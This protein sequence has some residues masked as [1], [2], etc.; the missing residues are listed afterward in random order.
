MRERS[1]QAG[2]RS[3]RSAET[4]PRRRP[5]RRPPC[6]PT[7]QRSPALPPPRAPAQ[8]AHRP[9]LRQPRR[10]WEPATKQ[11]GGD[12]AEATV[13]AHGTPH[14]QPGS[15]GSGAPLPSI[16][17]PRATL[18]GG[19]C[20]SGVPRAPVNRRPAA[21]AAA[22][23]WGRG[24]EEHG[25]GG[26]SPRENAK[27]TLHSP[28]F[29][30]PPFSCHPKPPTATTTALASPPGA[31]S[32]GRRGL[33]EEETLTSQPFPGLGWRRRRKPGLRRQR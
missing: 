7:A 11:N 13:A 21:R 16:P 30:F 27:G 25:G 14:T 15:D 26:G 31:P 32:Q 24:R 19:A 12:R 4:Q 8:P 9:S 28:P 23:T 22:T 29:C 6:S 17:R 2:E 20:R 1:R 18:S 10:T 3:Q 5:P 33:T